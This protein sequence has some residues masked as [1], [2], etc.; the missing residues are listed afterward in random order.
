MLAYPRAL[1]KMHH[2]HV[3]ASDLAV[4]TILIEL[5]LV[6]PDALEDAGQTLVVE[7]VQEIDEA[8]PRA[9]NFSVRRLDGLRPSATPGSIR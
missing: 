2:H 9:R 3:A 1:E 4:P 7:I 8:A 5:R 6:R